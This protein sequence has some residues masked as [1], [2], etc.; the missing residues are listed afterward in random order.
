MIKSETSYEIRLRYRDI[1]QRA[2][3]RV[4]D[5]IM[6]QGDMIKYEGRH[7]RM[8]G[9]VVG[10]YTHCILIDFGAYKECRRKADLYLGLC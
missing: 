8:T 6:V 10:V 7:E 3:F 2:V 9:T 5:K 4:G 1:L